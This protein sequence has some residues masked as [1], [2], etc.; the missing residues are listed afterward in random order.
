MVKRE[1]NIQERQL[2]GKGERKKLTK[3]KNIR[4]LSVERI[5]IKNE[6]QKSKGG[7]CR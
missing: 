7:K 5:K 3:H 2:T 6:Y 1:K 4:R